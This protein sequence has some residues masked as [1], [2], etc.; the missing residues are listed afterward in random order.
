MLLGLLCLIAAFVIR[1][2][3]GLVA[4]ELLNN[5]YSLLP[6][7]ERFIGTATASLLIAITFSELANLFLSEKDA[8]KKAIKF[9]GN[10]LEL[11]LETS[12]S[13]EELLQFTLDNGKFYIGWV[14]ELPVPH[15]SNYTRIIPAFSGYRNEETRRL[16]FTTQYLS[17]YSEYL[18][19]G[20]IRNISDIRSDLV[21]DIS[22]LVSVGYFDLEMYKR[23]NRGYRVQTE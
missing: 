23:F 17:V 19:E 20:K 9:N 8:I 2:I 13:D 3:T 10:E 4:P 16:I 21:I 22:N 14:K 18:L 7:N 15:V 11:M 1:Y 5:L 12:F 6:V